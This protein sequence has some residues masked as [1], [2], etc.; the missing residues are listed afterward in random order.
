MLNYSIIPLD[1]DHIDEICEDIRYQYENNIASCALFSMALVPEGNP[2]IDK[3][4]LFGEKY[5]LFRD[6]LRSMGLKCGILA[7][8]TIGHGWKLNEMFPYTQYTGL[9]DGQKT[10]TCCPQDDGF[11]DYIRNTFKTLAQYEPEIIMVDDDLRLMFRAG[12]GCACDLHMSMF[13]KLAGTNLT[14]EQLWEALKKDDATAREYTDAFVKT[15]FDSLIKAA[16]AMR[17]G[18]DSVD[19]SIPGAFCCCGSNPEAAGEIARILAGK[20]NPVVIRIN[21]GNYLCGGGRK[22]STVF[23]RAAT[24]MAKL[25]EYADVFLDEPDT[26]PQNRYS[27][28]AIA[29]HAHLSG[30]LLEG[31]GGAKHWITRMATHEPASGKAY[32]TKL[33]KHIGFYNALE[34]LAPTLEWQGCRIPLTEKTYFDLTL[35]YFSTEID[36][37]SAYV[38]E[39]MGLPL[40]F[41]SKPGGAV[42]MEGK[43]THEKFTDAEIAQFFGGTFFMSSDTAKALCERGYGDNIGVSVREW[44][45]KTMSSEILTINGNKCNVQHNAMELVPLS[46]NVKAHSYICYTLDKQEY[47][48]LFPGVTEYKNPLGGKTVVYCGSPT[49]ELSLGAPFSM[50]NESRKKQFVQLLSESGNL[51]LYY[52]DDGE[53]YLK[54]AKLP[55]GTAFCALFNLGIDTLDDIPLVCEKKYTR[56]EFLDAD[57]I[58]KPVNIHYDGERLVV[59]KSAALLEPVVLFLN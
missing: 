21:N 35:P 37:W 59:E 12:G 38:L 52:P 55:D 15:Q 18:I 11:C 1:T 6:K 9:K 5:A 19:P 50:L 33:S 58:R 42:F 44:Q 13:N 32:R 16:R 4:K 3:G 36:G 28:S 34:Q 51:P 30:A 2:T 41:S 22:F 23:Y 45:G 49:I 57:G 7:Q 10:N 46:D 43:H 8:A 26:C 53:V 54:A 39:R 14:R 24:Q 31:A 47:T 48:P 27:T 25:K 56:A 40:Y 17:E 29:L 20:G